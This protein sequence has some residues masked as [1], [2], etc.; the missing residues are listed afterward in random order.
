MFW[1]NV[2]P[3]SHCIC[4]SLLQI[5]LFKLTLNLTHFPLLMEFFTKTTLNDANIAV[6]YL[7]WTNLTYLPAFF[8][9][10]LLLIWISTAKGY[11]VMTVLPLTLVYYFYMVELED[12][13]LINN[14]VL[15]SD[16]IP[17]FFNVLLTNLLNKYHP[18]LL[19]LSVVLLLI[20]LLGLSRYSPTDSKFRLV[21]PQSNFIKIWVTTFVFNL[22]ALCLGGW[23]A[24]Q[25][26]TWGGWW[27]WDP[28]ETFGLLVSMAVLTLLHTPFSLHSVNFNLTKMRVLLYVFLLAY[29]FIQL[30][31]ETVSHNFSFTVFYFFNNSLL[32]TQ[33]TVLVTV[34][35][36][37]V[38]LLLGSYLSHQMFTQSRFLPL[39]SHHR[40]LYPLITLFIPLT[41]VVLP[42]LS[43]LPIFNYFSWNLFQ[44]PLASQTL[45]PGFTNWLMALALLLRFNYLPLSQLLLLLMLGATTFNLS[46]WLLPLLSTLPLL[47]FPVS[48][49]LL[50]NLFAGNFDFLAWTYLNSSSTLLL[51]NHLVVLQEPLF[52]TW[53]GVLEQIQLY[54]VV[55]VPTLL[56]WC[57]SGLTNTFETQIFLLLTFHTN[58]F[59][60]YHAANNYLTALILIELH[61]V[62][63]TFVFFMVTVLTLTVSRYLKVLKSTA[64]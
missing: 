22:I 31:F 43:Y 7:Y 48:L 52:F 8:A 64:V 60:L 38:S 51:N 39:L 62:S 26:G 27:N 21:G 33:I 4:W 14:S 9:S 11:R 42:T 35:L 13:L 47:H 36:L 41:F 45:N 29:Y 44:L 28:S 40:Q 10:L 32:F 25:E 54:G 1:A 37:K 2:S 57:V 59:N 34:L 46:Y 55:T 18:L 23:W 19:Y 3:I 20:E 24:L 58:V 5:F 12:F 6:F 56:T 50:L 63:A 61:G 16:T 30:N 17:Y 53:E 15:V 49:V